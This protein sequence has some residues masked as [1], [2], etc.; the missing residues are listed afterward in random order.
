MNIDLSSIQSPR[1]DISKIKVPSAI[2]NMLAL[3]ITKMYLTNT[4]SKEDFS[5]L[6]KLTKS[7]NK[8]FTIVCNTL[9]KYDD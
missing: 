9:E 5:N 7:F 8:V 4:L 1:V 6:E 3:E 2:D